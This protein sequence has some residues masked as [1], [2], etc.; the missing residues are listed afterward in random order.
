MPLHLSI[1]TATQRSLIFLVGL[2]MLIG[3]ATFHHANV[4]WPIVIAGLTLLGFPI[5]S[6]IDEAR[7]ARRGPEGE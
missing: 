5:P 1:T 2:G 6:L 4:Q 3:E 7:A